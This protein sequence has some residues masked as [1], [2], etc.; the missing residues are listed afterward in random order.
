MVAALAPQQFLA[1]AGGCGQPLPHVQLR[2]EPSSQ[3]LQIKAGSLAR[4]FLVDGQLQ[5]LPLNE[6][7]W[8]CGDR[9]AFSADGLQL[10]GRLDGAITSGGETVFPEQVG[11]APAGAKPQSGAAAG[12]AAAAA[13]TRSA[14]RGNG[15]WPW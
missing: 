14:L 11:A 9:G 4:G 15:W 10:L 1:G 12:G 13:G 2:L 8:S 6:G 5:P 3:G 7:W